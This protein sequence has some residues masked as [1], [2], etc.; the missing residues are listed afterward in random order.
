MQ[1]REEKTE[2]QLQETI[3]AADEQPILISDACKQLNMEAHVLRYWEEELGLPIMRNDQGY[4]CY[5]NA[6]LLMFQRIKILRDAGY[7]LKAI[8]LVVPRLALLDD[9]EFYYLVKLSDEMNKRASELPDTLPAILPVSASQTELARKLRMEEF[10][11]VMKTAEKAVRDFMEDRPVGYKIYEMEHPDVLLWAVWALQQYAKE[12]SREL[13][14][15]KYGKLLE[16]IMNYIR[17]R[18]HDNLFL[19]ENG[20]LYANGKEKAV[21]WMN[22]TANGHPVIPRTGYIVEVNALWYNALRFVA[23][24][25]REGGNDIFADELDDLAEM[26][27]KS[28]VEVFRNEY[29]YLFDYVDGY[30]MDWSVRPNMIFAVAFDYSPLD[31]A[32]KKQVLDIVTK[33]LLTPKGLRTLSPKSGGYNPNYVGPQV[34][35]DYAYHQGTAWPWLMGFYMEAYLRIY[36]MSGISFVERYLIGFED[37]MTSHCI[38]SLPEL[39]D[40]NPPFK[41]RGAVSFAMNVAEIL[42]ILKLLSK[43]NL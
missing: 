11:D 34:Q 41:G 43:Y 28:F 36:K 12:T 27:G 38:G 40:G 9:D 3:Q 30:M 42:R 33:E 8:K 4:R 7:Q 15:Q 25:V 2:Q 29:G 37:E 32:Q 5:T 6:Q 22:S 16:D 10:E 21:T 24:L 19:H 13:C 1:D 14:R 39:F 35:R 31:R 17:G 26:V 18:K 23:D 20:L